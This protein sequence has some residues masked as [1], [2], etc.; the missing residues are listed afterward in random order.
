MYVLHQSIRG[1]A[2]LTSEASNSDVSEFSI[3]AILRGVLVRI[4]YC[5]VSAAG[6]AIALMY[7][8]E[9]Y[10]SSSS[11]TTSNNRNQ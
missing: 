10:L 2:R 4:V 1:G 11:S 5:D 6:A 3:L 9:G 8:G 7:L